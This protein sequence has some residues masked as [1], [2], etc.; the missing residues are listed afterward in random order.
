M[1][2]K[3]MREERVNKFNMLKDFIQT[4][5]IKINK[6][7]ILNLKEFEDTLNL[8]KTKKNENLIF[9]IICSN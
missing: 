9:N 8:K 3:I 5:N 6:A 7:N 1:V 4:K 2:I